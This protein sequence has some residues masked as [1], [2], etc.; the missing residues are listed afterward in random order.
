MK[1]RDKPWTSLF[2]LALG[3]V[4]G[5]S[6]IT[7]LLVIVHGGHVI[8]NYNWNK[9]APGTCDLYRCY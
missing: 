9:T 6:V 7:V 5:L 4:I 1:D 3:I 8:E 2:S